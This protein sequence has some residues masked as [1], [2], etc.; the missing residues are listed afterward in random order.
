M[1][2]LI[3]NLRKSIWKMFGEKWKISYPSA[4]LLEEYTLYRSYT[5]VR[6]IG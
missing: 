6:D 4:V 5:E 2:N 3:V 1:P